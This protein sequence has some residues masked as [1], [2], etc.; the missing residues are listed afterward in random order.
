MTKKSPMEKVLL[1]REKEEARL[2]RESKRPLFLE[3]RY[4]IM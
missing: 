2:M 1:G 4:L 3:K